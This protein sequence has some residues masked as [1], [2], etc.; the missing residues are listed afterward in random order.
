MSSRPPAF[1][2]L[3]RVVPYARGNWIRLGSILGL[4]LLGSLGTALQ[5]WPLKLIVDHAL[6]KSGL[7]LPLPWLF[8]DASEAEIAITLIVLAA[9][10]SLALFLLNSALD[11][12]LT[13]V[14]AS[15]GQRITY[16]CATDVFDRLCRLR[17][18]FLGRGS[19]GDFLSRISIDSRAVYTVLQGLLMGPT[20]Q[21][22]TLWMV[23]G[24]A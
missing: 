11:A 7:A 15:M 6:A 9:V 5:P 18:T 23:A 12:L 14:G 16:A 24:F 19:V 13:Y 20:K 8:G 2:L 22:F 17:L 21:V 4:T 1:R 10:A 3:R